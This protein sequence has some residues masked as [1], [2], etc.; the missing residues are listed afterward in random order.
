MVEFKMSGLAD[1]GLKKVPPDSPSWKRKVMKHLGTPPLQ[2][3]E[4]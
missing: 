3:E 1:V 4:A 2:K